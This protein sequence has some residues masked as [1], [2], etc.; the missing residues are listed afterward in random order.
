MSLAV[1]N[2]EQRRQTLAGCLMNNARFVLIAQRAEEASRQGCV[3]RQVCHHYFTFYVVGAT[4][5]AIKTT[6]ITNLSAEPWR[7]LVK[8]IRV[9]E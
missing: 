9:S 4:Q 7:R 6:N 8:I 3:A 5:A 1:I 2:A